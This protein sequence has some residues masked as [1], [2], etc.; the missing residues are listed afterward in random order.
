MARPSNTLQRRAEIVDG[1]LAVMAR[2]GYERAT[3]AAIGKA[4]GLAPGLVHYHFASKGEVL[5]ELVARLI[6]SVRARYAALAETEDSLHAFIDAH[7]K[8]GPNADPRAVAAWSVVGAEAVRPGD[9]RSAYRRALAST[10]REMRR[11]V[12]ARLRDNG[13]STQNAGS[14]SAAL[15]AAVEGS[16]RVAASA[17]RLLPRGFAAPM[18]RRMADHLIASE[19][20]R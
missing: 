1:L 15:V 2:E 9:V 18:V 4:A 11:L 12:T 6:S 13:R 20:R 5:L 17:P 10:L 16:F 3:V 7:L 19:A 8:L 14:I